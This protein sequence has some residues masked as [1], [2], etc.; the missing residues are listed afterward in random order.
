[1]GKRK[2]GTT[3]AW[4]R[5]RK[6]RRANEKEIVSSKGKKVQKGQ[7]NQNANRNAVFPFGWAGAQ[8]AFREN[9]NGFQKQIGRAQFLTLGNLGNVCTNS[10]FMFCASFS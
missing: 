6:K 4:S 8:K 3:N 10:D 9:S 5:S 7:K 1:M 2:N